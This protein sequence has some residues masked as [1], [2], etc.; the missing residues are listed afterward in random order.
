MEVRIEILIWDK[1]LSKSLQAKCSKWEIVL[2]Q[3]STCFYAICGFDT[4]NFL[5]SE[6]RL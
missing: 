1:Q 4:F 5:A 6:A 3:S 2:W